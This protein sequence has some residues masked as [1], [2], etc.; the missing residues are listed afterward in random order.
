MRTSDNHFRDK[1]LIEKVR[2]GDHIAFKT[3][4]DLYAPGLYYSAYNLLRD[5]EVCEDLVQDLFLALWAKRQSL[6]ILSLKGY[7]YTAIKNRVLMVLRAGK[8]Q[9]DPL[10]AEVL[11]LHYSPHGE[12]EERE[13]QSI[14]DENME[15]LPARCK[16]IFQLSR[17]EHLSNKEIAARLNISPKT[18][19]NQ[20]TIALRQLRLKLRDFLF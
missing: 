19:E 11:S 17:R 1:D 12:L 14:L 15:V 9:I 10:A 13:I 4:Y 7:L 16:E 20:I 5:K 18:V 8:I 3:I 6:E 2:S